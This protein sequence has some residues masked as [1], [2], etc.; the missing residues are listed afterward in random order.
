MA[1][2]KTDMCSACSFVIPT[3]QPAMTAADLFAQWMSSASHNAQASAPFLSTF[4]QNPQQHYPAGHTLPQSMQPQCTTAA[5]TQ[6]FAP[7]PQQQQQPQLLGHTVPQPT[8]APFATSA[9]TQSPS[10]HTFNTPHHS[11]A[12]PGFQPPPHHNAAIPNPQLSPPQYGSLLN[13]Q[14]TPHSTTTTL[15]QPLPATPF[16]QQFPTT[17]ASTPPMSHNKHN[18]TRSRTTRKKHRSSTTRR[19]RRKSTKRHHSHYR[20]RHRSTTLRSRHHKSKH[21]SQRRRRHRSH[22]RQHSSHTDRSKSNHQSHTGHKP[23]ASS[24][25]HTTPQHHMS[26]LPPPPTTQLPPLPPPPLP[27][28][29]T[30][31]HL[32]STSPTSHQQQ[33]P[34]PPPL[35]PPTVPPPLS[36]ADKIR[37]I[38]KSKN[39]YNTTTSK[40][41]TAGQVH[42]TPRQQ[43][44][45]PT[46]LDTTNTTNEPQPTQAI[47][48][49]EEAIERQIQQDPSVLIPW[50]PPTRDS[51]QIF[52][53]QELEQ[54]LHSAT[55]RARELTA[56]SV[57]FRFLSDRDKS[58][59]D[60][61][62]WLETRFPA[63]IDLP[64]EHITTTLA[65]Y[66]VT[67]GMPINNT[68]THITF[69][70]HQ[71]FR[72]W[73]LHLKNMPRNTAI[74]LSQAGNAYYHW[75]HATSESGFLGILLHG[76]ILPTCSESMDGRK[77]H[78]FF[79]SATMEQD[80]LI[81]KVVHRYLS[82]KSHVPF[83]L[84]GQLWGTHKPV[85]TG[86][87]WAEQE[88][89][90][91]HG[92]V[93]RP[94]DRRWCI[95]STL[96]HISSIWI[97][98]PDPNFSTPAQHTL[99]H[100]D[101]FGEPQ[102]LPTDVQMRGC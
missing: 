101:G 29:Y 56:P 43:Y 51:Y 55:L 14:P 53:Y 83:I 54:R 93:H 77:V 7:I 89:V 52:N 68:L 65:K 79:C 13:Y 26:P 67:T 48:H 34:P 19:H 1:T 92:I 64:E 74:S 23:A 31:K 58:V 91:T 4:S 47:D 22:R 61:K 21:R 17:T 40:T 35:P 3:M 38:A 44:T 72:I 63:G 94:R 71:Q 6:P 46:P 84:T 5:F 87:T 62:E 24:Q 73:Q 30:G 99:A 85:P 33:P 36:L 102:L 9:F 16:S 37:S 2:L 39:T 95:H 20:S 12:M 70:Q 18:R 75:A 97:L 76:L 59:R 11:T 8:Q 80:N 66:I 88:E 57:Y 100:E 42:L 32:F 81:H 15:V 78:G 90:D 27:S 98:E 41:V 49:L 86:G 28:D 10:L 60:M 82:G 45:P 96:A 69:H 25:Q 50:E